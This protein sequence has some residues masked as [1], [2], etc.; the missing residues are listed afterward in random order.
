MPNHEPDSHNNQ[1]TLPMVAILTLIFSLIALSYLTLDRSKL[2]KSV[3]EEHNRAIANMGE[4][5]RAIRT[6]IGQHPVVPLSP[7]PQK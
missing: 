3:F 4:D 2:E 1:V 7:G 6:L 5:I